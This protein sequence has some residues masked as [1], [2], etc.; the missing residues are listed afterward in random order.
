MTVVAMIPPLWRR[1]MNPR[2]RQWRRQFY[3]E[4]TDWS[5]YKSATT[6]MPR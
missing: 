3:P 6:P 1:M 2:V 4:I 5:A